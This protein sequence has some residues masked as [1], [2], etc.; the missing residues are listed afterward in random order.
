M[1]PAE[2]IAREYP[3]SAD[4]VQGVLDAVDGDELLARRVLNCVVTGGPGAAFAEALRRA[5]QIERVRR[6]FAVGPAE[7]FPL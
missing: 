4:D 5:A 7:M 6:V 2:R 1:T 3:Y